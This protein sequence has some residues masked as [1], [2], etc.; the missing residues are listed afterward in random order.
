MVNG[1][2]RYWGGYLNDQKQMANTIN[3]MYKAI[4]TVESEVTDLTYSYLG[5]AQI[6]E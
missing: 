3:N 5:F 1:C 2:L 4:L 6:K